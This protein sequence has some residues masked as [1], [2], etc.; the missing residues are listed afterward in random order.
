MEDFPVRD[1]RLERWE[2]DEGSSWVTAIH[3]M[4]RAVSLAKPLAM[5]AICFGLT[6]YA[7]VN[8]MELVKKVIRARAARNSHGRAWP[9]DELQSDRGTESRSGAGLQ[10]TRA[11]AACP[12]TICGILM[13]AA[14]TSQ[15]LVQP[16]SWAPVKQSGRPCVQSKAWDCGLH[17]S[18]GRQRTFS[19]NQDQD[20]AE[21]RGRHLPARFVVRKSH[22]AADTVLPTESMAKIK[23]SDFAH[24]SCLCWPKLPGTNASVAY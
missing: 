6:L 9:Q 16:A 12:A 23:D 21:F 18:F 19:N 7:Q 10:H 3:C 8:I 20:R 24:F 4:T 17:T 11:R 22:N 13:Y 15:E 5:N 14:V 1:F 2:D